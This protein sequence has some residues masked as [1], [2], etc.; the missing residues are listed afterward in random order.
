[1]VHN[2]QILGFCG[3]TK[4]MNNMET[5]IHLACECYIFATWL[6]LLGPC[7]V[8]L[9]IYPVVSVCIV[10]EHQKAILFIGLKSQHCGALI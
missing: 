10:S 8:V 4:I 3:E 6:K 7:S 1:M 2:K 9:P 5:Q